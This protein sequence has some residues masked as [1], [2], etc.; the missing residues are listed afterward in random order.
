MGPGHHAASPT[1]DEG[2]LLHHLLPSAAPG[3]QHAC[4]IRG[5]VGCTGRLGPDGDRAGIAASPG[6]MPPFLDC[7]GGSPP[8]RG[9]ARPRLASVGI[10]NQT[11]PSRG[12][13]N[14]TT[15]IAAAPGGGQR[16]IDKPEAHDA[17]EQVVG[18]ALRYPP[19]R[20]RDSDRRPWRIPDCRSNRS[21]R[22][23]GGRV[24]VGSAACRRLS[25]RSAACWAG[26][27]TLIAQAG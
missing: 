16:D 11:R 3:R 20:Y 2:E 12:V 5:P 10:G 17:I 15:L 7:D 23:A 21:S 26:W 18:H 4:L 1:A 24:Q 14:P 22:H 25:L 27:S 8:P 19:R 13:P 9:T 6:G